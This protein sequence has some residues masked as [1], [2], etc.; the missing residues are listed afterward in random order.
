MFLKGDKLFNV[1]VTKV[2]LVHTTQVSSLFL[3]HDSDPHI[4]STG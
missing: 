1:P 2:Y 3:G 4:P